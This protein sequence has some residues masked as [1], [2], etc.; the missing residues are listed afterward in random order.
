MAERLV[1]VPISKE[2]RDEL[3]RVKG[4]MTYDQFLQKLLRNNF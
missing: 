2:T 3:K 1:E 4:V